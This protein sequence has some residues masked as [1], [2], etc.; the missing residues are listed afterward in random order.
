MVSWLFKVH[1][2]L[3]SKGCF[4]TSTPV[5]HKISSCEP[6]VALRAGE[7]AHLV[8]LGGG[9]GGSRLPLWLGHSTG[10]KRDSCLFG[11]VLSFKYCFWKKRSLASSSHLNLLKTLLDDW[12]SPDFCWYEAWPE[13]CSHCLVGAISE[14]WHKICLFVCGMAFCSRMEELL[15]SWHQT[16]LFGISHWSVKS[17]VNNC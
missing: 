7:F 11:A 15:G 5:F 9:G 14:R 12:W 2:D 6:I 17:S 16:G 3:W 1:Y 4:A 8:Y 10:W 13:E